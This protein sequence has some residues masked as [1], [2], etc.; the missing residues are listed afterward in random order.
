MLNLLLL[1]L[2]VR[3]ARV[4]WDV[5]KVGVVVEILV[6]IFVRIFLLMRVFE[7]CVIGMLL[8]DAALIWKKWWLNC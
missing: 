2:V 5:Q 1:M 4:L 7:N 8:I 6:F 3:L